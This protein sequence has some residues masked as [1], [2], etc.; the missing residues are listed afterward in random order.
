VPENTYVDDGDIIIGKCM[1]QKID[2]VIS[3][4]D[5]SIALKS[6]EFGFIDKNSYGDKYFTNV[7]GDGYNFCKIRMRNMRIP[8]IGD[9]FC[10]VPETDVLT[11]RGWKAITDISLG[12]EVAQLGKRAR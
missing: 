6:N 5:T 12:D 1:P 4:K 2:T 3:Y 8:T 7:N 9:K 10:L 11:S